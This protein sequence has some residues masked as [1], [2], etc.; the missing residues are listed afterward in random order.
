MAESLRSRGIPFYVYTTKDK[1]VAW[2]KKRNLIQGGGVFPYETMITHIGGHDWGLIGNITKHR[3]WTNAM[4]NKL[5]EY[6][7]AQVPIVALN[8]SHAGKWIEKEGIGINISSLDELE[9][10]WGEKEECRNN[11]IKKR[12]NYTMEKHIPA[13][14][15]FYEEVIH[16]QS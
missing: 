8:A 16:L 3:E 14:E 4:P 1:A 15:K 9:E 10:R 13:L 11:L 2:Y 6:I 12:L 7:A 5:F